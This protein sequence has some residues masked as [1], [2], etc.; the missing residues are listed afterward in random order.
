MVVVVVVIGCDSL[1][2]ETV[3]SRWHK[4]VSASI[5]YTGCASSVPSQGIDTKKNI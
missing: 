1:I 5:L 3:C 2:Q 4:M